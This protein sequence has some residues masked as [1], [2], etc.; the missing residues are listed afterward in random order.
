MAKSEQGGWTS[1]ATY[2]VAVIGD[3]SIQSIL[4]T[5]RRGP[6]ALSALWDGPLGAVDKQ[7]R[8]AGLG[9][10]AAWRQDATGALR[11]TYTQLSHYLTDPST[12]PSPG[13]AQAKKDEQ[14]QE[15]NLAAMGTAIDLLGATFVRVQLPSQCEGM[16][17]Q[18]PP[19]N[20]QP[21]TNAPMP[22][23]PMCAG[24]CAR[25]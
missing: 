5:A 25:G 3:E 23:Y 4:L 13:P 15:A 14:E 9:F 18:R 24:P 11:I 16:V 10:A 1:F 12:E 2:A 19:F 8:P 20:R 21:C 6:V 7:G 22:G 17:L